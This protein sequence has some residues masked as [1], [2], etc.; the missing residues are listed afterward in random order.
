MEELQRRLIM[1]LSG[2]SGRP[3][4]P[5]PMPPPPPP[6]PLPSEVPHAMSV[7]QRCVDPLAYL[8]QIDAAH[9]TVH[10]GTGGDD[11]DDGGCYLLSHTP[12]LGARHSFDCLGLPT[13]PAHPN[14]PAW[15]AWGFVSPE[16]WS[17]VR[18]L[19]RPFR[20][21][22]LA[23]T[24][25]HIRQLTADATLEWMHPGDGRRRR[26]E[27]GAKDLRVAVHGRCLPFLVAKLPRALSQGQLQRDTVSTQIA[28]LH[29]TSGMVQE[30]RRAT[31]IERVVVDPS[32]ESL[33]AQARKTHATSLNPLVT[34]ADELSQSAASNRLLEKPLAAMLARQQRDVRRGGLL[35]LAFNLLVGG[36][37]VL[38]A[39]RGVQIWSM[40]Q[41][42]KV[43]EWIQMFRPH[44]PATFGAVRLLSWASLPLRRLGQPIVRPVVRLARGHLPPRWTPASTASHAASGS[45]AVGAAGTSKPRPP[46]ERPACKPRGSWATRV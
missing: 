17:Y 16:C 20:P 29:P 28:K 24:S 45:A 39:V 40:V 38:V 4:P 35:L 23:A 36:L 14:L 13:N 33:L 32:A 41:E 18:V 44:L 30:E 27:V 26:G 8:A 2:W 15:P 7:R 12:T 11:I 19:R 46:T 43:V 25:S 3:L 5:P 37:N 9:C 22:S 21:A 10:A 31:V 34:S 42:L 1:P 6:M